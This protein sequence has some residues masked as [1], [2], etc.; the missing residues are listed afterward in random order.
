MPLA[1]DPEKLD[2]RGKRFGSQLSTPVEQNKPSSPPDRG[3]K[4]SAPVTESVDE[5]ELE[6][7]KK[8]GERFGTSTVSLFYHPFVF[9]G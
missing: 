7:R 9:A 3:N 2:A 5:A 6:R 8:R 1:Q 4:R